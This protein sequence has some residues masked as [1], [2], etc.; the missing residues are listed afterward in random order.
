MVTGRSHDTGRFHGVEFNYDSR[1][2]IRERA[3]AQ[4][5]P[6]SSV[7]GNKPG[8]YFFL[9]WYNNTAVCQYANA[10]TVFSIGARRNSRRAGGTPTWRSP[11]T[12]T[13]LAD[14]YTSVFNNAGLFDLETHSPLLGIPFRLTEVL[15]ASHRGISLPHLPQSFLELF[16][17]IFNP[18]YSPFPLF[19]FK[20][21]FERLREV[22]KIT[23]IDRQLSL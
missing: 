3:S 15:W 11:S 4:L 7:P 2:D 21:T 9:K 22:W 12:W 16:L 14:N 10:P 17:R 19:L 18:A 5:K 20:R 1:N 13:F 6:V 8:I 23:I